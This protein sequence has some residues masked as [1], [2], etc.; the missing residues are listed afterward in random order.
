M[1]T[2][3]PDSDWDA[4]RLGYLIKRVEL[5]LRTELDNHL[6]QFG[7][8][9]QQYAV[10]SVLCRVDG[11]SSAD[12]ARYLRVSPQATT[13]LVAAL[14]RR[15]FVVRH[16]DPN[17]RK[18]LRVSVTAE[19]RRILRACD[20]VRSEIEEVMLGPLD[21]RERRDLWTALRKCA[22][23]LEVLDHP[24]PREHGLADDGDAAWRDAIRPEPAGGQGY[25]TEPDGSLDYAG[26]GTDD[27][28]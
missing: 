25:P 10:L 26:L 20:S 14:Q 2:V 18:I 9:T 28:R 16:A 7:L 8:T 23:A 1:W 11:L 5:G 19:G 4:P 13:Q 21:E 27:G 15:G 6:R 3:E 24:R 17:H 12:L 22:V